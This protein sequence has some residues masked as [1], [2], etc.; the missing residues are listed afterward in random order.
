MT[1]ELLHKLQDWAYLF[2]YQYPPPPK[3]LLC[4]FIL[5]LMVARQAVV[6]RIESRYAGREY[7]GG[8]NESIIHFS[9][10]KDFVNPV[11]D[12]VTYCR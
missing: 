2:N 11:P 4:D 6:F 1:N 12:F 5:L 7:P 10:Q 9:E 3:K 8:S